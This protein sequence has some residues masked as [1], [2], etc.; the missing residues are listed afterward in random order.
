M[1]PLIDRNGNMLVLCMPHVDI[2]QRCHD[3]IQ[4]VSL[5]EREN[6]SNLAQQEITQSFQYRG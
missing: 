4:L 2:V 6:V 3:L 5:Y 1:E